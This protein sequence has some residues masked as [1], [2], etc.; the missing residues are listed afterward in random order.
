M[1]L[2]QTAR[3]LEIIDLYHYGFLLTEIARFYS[4]SHQRIH[5]I[6]KV[7]GISNLDGGR[8]IVRDKRNQDKAR[9]REERVRQK[10]GCSLA[11]YEKLRGEGALQ[12]SIL[13]RFKEQRKNAKRRNIE[14]SLTLTEWWSL[15]EGKFHNRGR[16]KGQFVMSRHGDK[17]AYS[18]D[19]VEIVTTTENVLEHYELTY[20]GDYS[21]TLKN[22]HITAE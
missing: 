17:G 2:A 6:L 19:N 5:Q 16:K 20:G 13:W 14:W 3:T 12:D 8:V 1:G 15:W 18:V 10:F 4:V 21:E 11:L 22:R 9:Y 7:N